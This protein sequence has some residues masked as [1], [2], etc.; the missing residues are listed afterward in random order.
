MRSHPSLFGFL[1]MH[2]ILSKLNPVELK[3]ALLWLLLASL[4]EMDALLAEARYATLMLSSW[5]LP[6]ILLPDLPDPAALQ[7]DDAP[8]L[9]VRGQ[10]ATCSAF[11]CSLN[12][13]CQM[14]HCQIIRALMLP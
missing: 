12:G 11:S 10:A 9:S 13:V 4:D 5:R 8:R 1:H 3:P 6:T 14:Q 2:A 7:K